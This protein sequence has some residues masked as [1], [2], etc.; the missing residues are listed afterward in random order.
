[1]QQPYRV[2]FFKRLVDSTGHPVDAVQGEVELDA[3]NTE[4]AMDD[5]RLAFAE[6][7]QVSN[8]LLRADYMNVELLAAAEQVRAA[9]GQK[10][11]RSARR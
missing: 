7:K 4:S 11:V 8:W 10:R 5:A 6:R 1:M 2:T 9:G 3:S